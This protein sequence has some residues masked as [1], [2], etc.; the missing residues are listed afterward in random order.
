MPAMFIVAALGSSALDA[1]DPV[2]L[3]ARARAIARSLASLARS[4]ALLVLHHGAHAMAPPP[5]L[6]PDLAAASAAGAV[7]HLLARELRNAL[8][9]A[10]VF[11]VQAN[12]VVPAADA[13]AAATPCRFVEIELLQHLAQDERMLLCVACVPVAIDSEG[14]MAHSDAG[15]DADAAAACLATELGADILL[16]LGNV[17]AVY[18]DW[19][20]RHTRIVALDPAAASAR[21]LEAPAFAATLAAAA[22][23]ADSGE[24]GAVIGSAIEAAA[25]VAGQAGTRVSR[26]S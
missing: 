13:G 17:D 4:H 22:R 15:L 12:A 21:A 20:A 2:A 23:V 14:C 24:G 11:A 26:R 8:P 7:G 6:P 10:A 9:R 5:G 1:T 25:L 16:L 19:P 3:E 18:E